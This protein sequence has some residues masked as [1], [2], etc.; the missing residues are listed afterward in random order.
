MVPRSRT[1]QFLSRLTPERT[2]QEVL[3]VQGPGTLTEAVFRTASGDESWRIDVN[4]DGQTYFSRSIAEIREV[5]SVS[6]FFAVYFDADTAELSASFGPVHF[7]ESI[8]IRILGSGLS[9][10]GWLHWDEL[11]NP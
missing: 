4:I 10:S 11:R 2:T 1:G 8:R 5:T 3:N 7:R 9:V 6:G